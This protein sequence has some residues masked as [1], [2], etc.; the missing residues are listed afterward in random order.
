[1]IKELADNWLM[2]RLVGLA[3]SG[4][5]GVMEV[6]RGVERTRGLRSGEK[7]CRCRDTVPCLIF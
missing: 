2:G 3:V 7:H 6:D 1:M 4:W 5:E